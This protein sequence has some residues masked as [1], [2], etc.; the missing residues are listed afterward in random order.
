MKLRLTFASVCKTFL[1]II[2]GVVNIFG[3]PMNMC[4]LCDRRLEPG[5]RIMG[6]NLTTSSEAYVVVKSK[7]SENVLFSGSEYIPGDV[8]TIELGQLDPNVF[9]WP[10]FEISGA[11]FDS[12]AFLG[13]NSTRCVDGSTIVV[14]LPIIPTE[15]ITVKAGYSTFDKIAKLT[16][17]LTFYPPKT[18]NPSPLP[19]FFETEK[20]T[21]LPSWNPSSLPTS[22]PTNIPTSKPSPIPSYKPTT[23]P[24][25]KP[26]KIPTQP[27]TCYPTYLPS[28]QPSSKP[29]ISPIYTPTFAPTLI[30][31]EISSSSPT[32]KKTTF[33]LSQVNLLPFVKY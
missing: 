16:E 1:L 30:P 20:P 21:F 19:T 11:T 26:T 31:T 12:C 29:T 18:S 33:R 7:E 14:T 10:V 17:T 27:P 6:N 24:T 2:F 22:N 15:I 23:K 9:F 25:T 13:C 8:V 28:F 5:V 4:E 3:Y 32:L